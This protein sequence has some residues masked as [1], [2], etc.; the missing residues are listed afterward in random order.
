MN[1]PAHIASPAVFTGFT[2]AEFLRMADTGAFT[3][4]RVELVEGEIVKMMPAYLAHGEANMR[5]GAQLMAAFGRSARVAVDLM[6]AT[7]A[8]T[9]RAAD[10]AVV[11]GDAA[12]DRPLDP[13]DV[14]LVVEIAGASLAEDLGPKQQDYARAGIPYYWVV[15][16]AAATVHA[17]REPEGGAYRARDVVRFGEP[18]AVPG[19]DATIVIE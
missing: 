18:I 3:D 6:I 8:D 2:T 1:R 7:A 17:M 13:A 14:L 12:R 16:L 4:L 5:L 9:I 19:T 15:D 11:R 10:I